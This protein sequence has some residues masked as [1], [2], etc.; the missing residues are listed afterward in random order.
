MV[1]GT[2]LALFREHAWH[3]TNINDRSCFAGT[4]LREQ[5]FIELRSH[6]TPLCPSSISLLGISLL[7]SFKI[8]FLHTFRSFSCCCLPQPSYLP[9]SLSLFLVTSTSLLPFQQLPLGFQLPYVYPKQVLQSTALL[10]V[11]SLTNN[12]QLGY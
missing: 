7:L 3:V 2:S 11:K 8:Q 5:G 12:K 4:F 6:I 10:S 9:V 1:S